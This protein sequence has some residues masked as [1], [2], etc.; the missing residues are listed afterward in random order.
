MLVISPCLVFF[1]WWTHGEFQMLPKLAVCGD[2]P[3]LSV[4][5]P[6][7][8]DLWREETWQR[9][10]AAKASNRHWPSIFCLT[11]LNHWQH[12]DAYF[13]CAVFFL[14]SQERYEDTWPDSTLQTPWGSC[15]QETRFTCDGLWQPKTLCTWPAHV[16]FN[17]EK[18][19]HSRK[20]WR[21]HNRCG[22]LEWV[23]L[24]WGY[25]Y[26]FTNIW[27]R[28]LWYWWGASAWRHGYCY[29]GFEISITYRQDLHHSH[30][31]GWIMDDHGVCIDIYI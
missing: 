15:L 11:C 19:E 30:H 13:K 17:L 2:D 26:I 3:Q 10:V 8:L 6:E 9:E 20:K 23:L 7:A 18:E 12:H 28:T 25:I 31:T 4:R 14:D 16:G 29:N 24:V 5:K 1:L 22:Q 21:F 27:A